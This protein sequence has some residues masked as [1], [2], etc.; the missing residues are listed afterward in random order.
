MIFAKCNFFFHLLIV[1]ADSV[2]SL[3]RCCNEGKKAAKLVSGQ[4]SCL[5]KPVAFS[6]PS[7]L[8]LSIYKVCC[9]AK[10][11]DQE[12]INGENL[13]RFLLTL[14]L[15]KLFQSYV[16]N[17]IQ[18]HTRKKK[19]GKGGFSTLT[20]LLNYDIQVVALKIMGEK[21]P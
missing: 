15:T 19:G 11:R 4:T 6:Q 5:K 21:L 8:C 20:F 7:K 14:V 18:L 9:L 10:E 12:C 16:V 1:N 13:S 2:L 17:N 3:A